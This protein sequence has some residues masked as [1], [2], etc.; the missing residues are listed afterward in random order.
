MMREFVT[1]ILDDSQKSAALTAIVQFLRDKGV[2]RVKVEFGF[3][4]NRD[5][6]GQEQGE[7]AVVPLA[8]LHSFIERGLQQGTIE[9]EGTSGLRY[10]IPG[11]DE[12]RPALGCLSRNLDERWP[13]RPLPKASRRTIR[14]LDRRRELVPIPFRK[15]FPA[16]AI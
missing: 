16:W 14:L 11:L 9:W 12:A 7:N 2:E 1:E 10:S 4:Y 13:A 5:L 15:T 6:R 3:V 8:E